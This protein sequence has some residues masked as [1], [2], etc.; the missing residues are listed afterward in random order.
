MKIKTSEDVNI[1]EETSFFHKTNLKKDKLSKI[2]PRV[3]QD[4]E[5]IKQKRNEELY[6]K[7]LEEEG[8]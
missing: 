4:I 5:K 3:L 1:I 6:I 2:N 7:E 8:L